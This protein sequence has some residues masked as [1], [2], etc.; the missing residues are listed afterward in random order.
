M[1]EVYETT[2]EEYDT[3]I[4]ALPANT[5]EAPYDVVITLGEAKPRYLG[6]KIYQAQRYV[7]V[8]FAAQ[9][10]S[11]AIWES[12]FRGY[13]LSSE[14]YVTNPYLINCDMTNLDCSGIKDMESLFFYCTGLKTVQL[15][16]LPNLTNAGKMFS[17][18]SSLTGVT[19]ASLPKVTTADSMFQYCTSLTGVTLPAMPGVTNANYMFLM[20]ASLT[21][22]DISEMT[23]LTK[24]FSMFEGCTSLASVSVT[25]SISNAARMFYGC[26]ALTT[27]KGLQWAVE[28]FTDTTESE[29]AEN[30][31]RNIFNGCTS[32]AHIY[33]YG[34]SDLKKT[35]ND[36]RLYKKE[37]NSLKS[38]DTDGTLQ[39]NETLENNVI[40]PTGRT[41]SLLFD[42]QS[43]DHEKLIA[44]P[45]LY[46]NRDGSLFDAD[47]GNFALIADDP[48]KTVTNIEYF[49]KITASK[50]LVIP[51]AEP[52]EDDLVNGCMWIK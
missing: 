30:S 17:A 21:E 27:V 7:N 47:G 23:A 13:N 3:V 9:G 36:W 26:S 31:M 49:K 11:A 35:C 10:T 6:L 45:Y 12:A 33:F 20:C 44:N 16:D 41:L 39:D 51:L 4:G 50:K 52:D 19:F 32:L 5:A 37:G 22:A 42:S 14:S 15:P 34:D 1:S 46:E 48:K 8:S 28:D 25:K 40:M 43:I 29:S 18:C 2:L 24:G 38:Y